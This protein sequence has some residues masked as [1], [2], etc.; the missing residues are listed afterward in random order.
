MK[1][2]LFG[3]ASIGVGGA[4]WMGWDSPDFDR[5]ISRPPSAV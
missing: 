2:F 5:T 1:N 4:A 3:V